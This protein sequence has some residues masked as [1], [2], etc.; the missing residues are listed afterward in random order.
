MLLAQLLAQFRS[1][2]R[3]QVARRHQSGLLERRR[4]RRVTFCRPF[5]PGGHAQFAAQLL[6]I[7]LAVPPWRP[8]W[9]GLRRGSGG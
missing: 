4:C 3:A 8:T 2:T 1:F 9:T 6:A 5:R 7:K